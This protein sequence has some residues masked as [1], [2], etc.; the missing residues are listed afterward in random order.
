MIIYHQSN[1]AAFAGAH[2]RVWLGQP[3]LLRISVSDGAAP[4]PSA[5]SKGRMFIDVPDD[6]RKRL[7]RALDRNYRE[8]EQA[9]DE[10]V[11]ILD[12]KPK[13]RKKPK[14]QDKEIIAEVR[15]EILK[16][17]NELPAVEETITVFDDL[18]EAIDQIRKAQGY[19]TAAKKARQR[20]ARQREEYMALWAQIRD[21]DDAITLLML[22][23]LL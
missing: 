1:V 13:G 19:S 16:A 20:L 11:E 7:R 2:R 18:I 12:A 9:L 21:D 4:A 17:K 5:E 3:S 22:E 23:G 10:A 14:L 6:V 8:Q 15:A